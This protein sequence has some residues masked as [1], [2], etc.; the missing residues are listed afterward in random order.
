MKVLLSGCVGIPTADTIRR[1]L[2]FALVG[3]VSGCIYAAV[4]SVSIEYLSLPPTAAGVLGYLASIP[5]NFIGHKHFA[6]RTQGR[7]AA[8][9]TKYALSTLTGIL[10]SAAI[11][12]FS[13]KWGIGVLGGIAFAILTIPIGTFLVFNN[14]VFGGRNTVREG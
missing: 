7:F 13:V 14:W 11:M 2:R 5:L 8:E 9:M 1:F 4:V 6:F 3:G 10:M 12:H